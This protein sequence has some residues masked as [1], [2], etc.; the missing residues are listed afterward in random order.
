M[1]RRNFLHLSGLSALY[2]LSGCRSGGGLGQTARAEEPPSPVALTGTLVLVELGGGND[3][4][5]TVIPYTDDAYYEARP[6]LAIPR[7]A[8]LPL[9]DALGLSPQLEPLMASWQAGDLAVVSGVG[10]PEPNRS[11]FRSIEIWETA[12]DAHRTE[13]QGW[14]AKTL[15]DRLGRD[16]VSEGMVLGD[17]EEGPLAGGGG[18]S[19]VMSTPGNFLR[20]ASRLPT[21]PVPAGNPALGHVVTVQN[22]LHRAAGEIQKRLKRAPTLGV[23]FP[24]G[25]LGKQLEVAARLILAGVTVPVIKV[26]LPG[27]DT[28]AGQKGMHERLLTQLGAC[29]DV[30]RS[31]LVQHGMWDQVLV[32]TYSE[33][34]RRVAENG[35]RGTDHGTAAPHFWM[36]GRVQGGLYG[37]QPS[38]TDL[39][40]GDLQHAVDFRSLYRTIAEDWWGVS[41]MLN[42]FERLPLLG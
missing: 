20:K 42:G 6:E 10:Y 34:G 31:C 18:R 13:T 28:H 32:S 21:S 23:D 24:K 41:G 36:G 16:V 3:G 37:A 27:F 19:L 22:E 12:S 9:S 4:L 17:G 5:N 8:V 29:L 2:L 35:S 33:F 25:P 7:D 40:D 26:S 14:I 1:K 38:L 15:S 11:H 30:F 39:D